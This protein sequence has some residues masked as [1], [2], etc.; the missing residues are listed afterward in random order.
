MN[1]DPSEVA[2]PTELRPRAKKKCWSRRDLNPR[3]TCTSTRHW[4]PK[5]ATDRLPYK[6]R[7]LTRNVVAAK[8]SFIKEQVLRRSF[9]KHPPRGRSRRQSDATGGVKA[10]QLRSHQP[11]GWRSGGPPQTRRSL[12]TPGRKIRRCSRCPHAPPPG[13]SRK[14]EYPCRPI[15]PADCAA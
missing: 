11:S 12:R 9:G 4:L 8:L 5:P 15:A 6:G 14:A 7:S 13:S 1:S 10:P 3:P 2:L